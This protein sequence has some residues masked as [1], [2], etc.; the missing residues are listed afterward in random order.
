MKGHGKA[1]RKMTNLSNQPNNRF[2][3]WIHVVISVFPLLNL[4]SFVS[5][6]YY[7]YH[8]YSRWPIPLIDS[9]SATFSS[10]EPI[11][12]R[13]ENITDTVFLLALLSIPVWFVV[14][15]ARLYVDQKR[16]LRMPASLF[17]GGLIANV[18]ALILDTHHFFLWWID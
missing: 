10:V 15:T 17:F 12:S 3:F 13:F 5:Y 11:I 7:I 16:N 2:L 9:P 4:A 18:S 1:K 14:L 6:A 8:L